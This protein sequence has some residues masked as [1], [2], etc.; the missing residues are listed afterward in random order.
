[1]KVRFK[2]PPINELV[3]GAYFDSPA[4]RS[5]HVGLL[6]SRLRDDFPII[7]QRAPLGALTTG[8]GAIGAISD[9]ELP[10]PR[11]WFVSKDDVNLI[12]VQRDAF[13]FN[14]RKRESKYPRFT[15]HLKPSFDKYYDIL[16][17]FACEA[18]SLG[19]I[20]IRRCE[21]TYVDLIRP[22]EYWQG[23]ADT[24]KLIPPF[25]LPD[26]GSA[27]GVASAFDCSYHFE[28]VSGIQLYVAIR[29]GEANGDP[30]SPVLVLEFK[31][32]G[33]VGGIPK[34]DTDA[35]CERAHDAI[36]TCFLNMTS[37]EIQ[38]K[39]WIPEGS[40]E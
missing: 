34:S 23:P 15:E 6:W 11:F 4:L 24:P 30:G 19:N 37:Q 22:C 33:D 40:P 31:A 1:M 9:G 32:L 38:R 10:M 20:R 14:W 13:L 28:P 12:Q 16:E 39:Y 36:V 17:T 35:W 2:N 3:I 25:A 26:C 8:Q 5:E 29:T 27:H 18:P 7:K 21:L